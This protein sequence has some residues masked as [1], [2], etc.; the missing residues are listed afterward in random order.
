MSADP[1]AVFRPRRGRVVPQ[2]MAVLSVIVFT[3]V[4]LTVTGEGRGGW[5]GPDRMLLILFGLGFAGMLWKFSQVRAEPTAEGLT[6]HNLLVTRH[7]EWSQ[8][9]NVQLSGSWAVLELDDTDT[10]AVMAI[11]R[12]DGDRAMAEAQRLAALVEGRR[13]GA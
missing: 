7:L 1:Y 13:P 2:V 11:Q 4:A 10:V 5:G 8:I 9:V 12:S 3:T 6:V